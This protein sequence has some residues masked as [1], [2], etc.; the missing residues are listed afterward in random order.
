MEKLIELDDQLIAVR[1]IGI[2]ELWTL[3]RKIAGS[4][5]ASADAWEDMVK[6]GKLAQ[7]LL[8]VDSA[9][10]NFMKGGVE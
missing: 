5:K 4:Y 9:R 2:K 6:L 3:Y 1:E 7:A 10:S 8:D